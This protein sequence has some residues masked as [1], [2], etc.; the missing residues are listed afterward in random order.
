[1]VE[2]EIAI[3]TLL[4]FDISGEI[5]PADIHATAKLVKNSFKTRHSSLLITFK[6]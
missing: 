1:M 2:Y 4:D 3:I 5:T 6:M